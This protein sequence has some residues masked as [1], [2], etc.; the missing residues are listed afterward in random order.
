MNL[1]I[2]PQRGFRFEPVGFYPQAGLVGYSEFVVA[3][4]MN[5]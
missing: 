3:L 4:K 1:V 2:K 5:F